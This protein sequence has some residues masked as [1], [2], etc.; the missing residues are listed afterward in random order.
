MELA[1]DN[2]ATKFLV[3]PCES[4]THIEAK[5]MQIDKSRFIDFIDFEIDSIK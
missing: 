2:F 5:S 1:N 4:S 3:I